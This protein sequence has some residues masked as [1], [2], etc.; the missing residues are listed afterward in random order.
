M[1]LVAKVRDFSKFSICLKENLE[2]YKNNI[3]VFIA[4]NK[5]DFF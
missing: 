4:T 1:F 2:I 3:L 5:K